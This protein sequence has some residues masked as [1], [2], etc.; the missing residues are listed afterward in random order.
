MPK[1][2]ARRLRNRLRLG[3]I[4]PNNI[5]PNTHVPVVVCRSAGI[6]TRG[7]STAHERPGFFGLRQ[8]S[9]GWQPKRLVYLAGRAEGIPPFQT[10]ALI[11][12]DGASL[13]LVMAT[14]HHLALA[15][16]SDGS[17]LSRGFVSGRGGGSTLPVRVSNARTG[18]RIASNPFVCQA[19][20]RAA[21]WRA[22]L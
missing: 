17:P 13:R 6:W 12:V 22:P 14:A 20:R 8:P 21:R 16:P 19:R 9:K 10:M 3:T 2:F 7:Q 1:N 18:G 15:A 11:P 5:L 4:R